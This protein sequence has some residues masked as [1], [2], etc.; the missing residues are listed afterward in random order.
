MR[1][2]AKAVSGLACRRGTGCCHIVIASEATK[3]SSFAATKKAGLLR[4]FAPRND[5]VRSVRPSH[6]VSQHKARPA[7]LADAVAELVGLSSRVGAEAHLVERRSA[8]AAEAR[9]E[10]GGIAVADH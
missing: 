9:G 6:P 3:Q 2:Q 8:T 1:R 10:N 4:R 7:G 5:G